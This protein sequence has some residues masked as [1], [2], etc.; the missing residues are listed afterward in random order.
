MSFFGE[1]DV[2]GKVCIGDTSLGNYRPK[3]IQP[4]SNINKITRGC[5]TCISAMLLQQDLNKWR[6]SKLA[7]LDKLYINSY[8]TRL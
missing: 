3:N 2:D 4:I 7:K 1:R 8:S 6:L 5:E